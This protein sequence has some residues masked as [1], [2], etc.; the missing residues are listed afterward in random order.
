VFIVACL[1][2]CMHKTNVTTALRNAA[3]TNPFEVITVRLA[4][5]GTI[6]AARAAPLDTAEQVIRDDDRAQFLIPQ[7]EQKVVQLVIDAKRVP[8]EFN[9]ELS[10]K[11]ISAEKQKVRVT[12]H[13]GARL[14][15]SEYEVSGRAITPLE[16]GYEDLGRTDV[17]KYTEK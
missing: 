9:A 16:S 2:G 5:D 11:R 17:V 6:A 3:Y 14:Y 4:D 7:D 15:Y 12:F 10:V 1:P 13:Y 8:S